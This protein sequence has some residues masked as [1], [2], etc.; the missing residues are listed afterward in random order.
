MSNPKDDPQNTASG[1]VLKTRNG[2]TY[3]IPQKV[4]DGFSVEPAA[5]REALDKIIQK[6]TEMHEAFSVNIDRD[7]LRQVFIF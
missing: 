5:G 7:L 6:P 1:V 4:L 3:F 2:K